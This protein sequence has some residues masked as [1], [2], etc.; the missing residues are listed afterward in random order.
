MTIKNTL[1]SAVLFVIFTV[2]ISGWRNAKMSSMCLPLLYGKV[3]D[4]GCHDG[5]FASQLLEQST[6]MES[7]YGIDPYLPEKTYIP[8]QYYDGVNIPFPDKEFDVVMCSFM[9]H[10]AKDPA[11]V[12]REAKRVGKRVVILE[13]YADTWLARWTTSFIVHDLVV[14][15]FPFMAYE[16]FRTVAEWEDMF[17]QTGLKLLAKHE[18][19]S[20]AAYV[21]FLRHI[22][23]VVVDDQDEEELQK[24]VQLYKPGVDR[25]DVVNIIFSLAI[26]YLVVSRCVSWLGKA[27]PAIKQDKKAN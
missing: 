22:V 11:Q 12:L 19:T 18:Y 17:Q 4:V 21:P 3:L 1:L 16:K 6:K 27:K 5:K 24:P 7:I 26:A 14:P 10:H 25:T 15:F 8:S 23:F 20:T 2:C 13:D 9:L